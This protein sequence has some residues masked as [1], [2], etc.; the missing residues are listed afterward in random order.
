MFKDRANRIHI[1]SWLL[2]DMAWCLHLKLFAT[3]MIFPTLFMTFY[4][5]VTQKEDRFDNSVLAAW[6][7]MNVTWMLH[8]LYDIPKEFVYFF[9]AIGIFFI[10]LKVFETIFHKLL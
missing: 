4:V 9:I 2:K 6:V 3:L 10:F 5:L 7:M 8:E 1:V